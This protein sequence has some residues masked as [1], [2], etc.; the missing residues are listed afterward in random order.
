M[1]MTLKGLRL[2]LLS[3]ATVGA[4]A[5]VA[6]PAQAAD[7]NP[8]RARKVDE[9][10][11]LYGCDGGVRLDNFAIELQNVPGAKGYII[12]RDARERMRGAAHAW[13]EYF[14]KYFVEYR[15][16]E[17]SRLVLLDAADVP[18]E[19]LSM[20]LWLVPEGAE[21]PS[22]KPPGKREPRPFSGKFAELYVFDETA[23]YD[24]EGGSAGSFSTGIIYASFA[25]LLKKQPDSQGYLVV[26]SPPG[27][28]PGY[29]RRAGTRERQKVSRDEVTA[30]RMTV[31][32]G[33]AV[34][35]KKRKAPTAEGEVEEETYGRV[36][37]W[38]GPKEKPPVKH[39]EENSTLKEAL[40]VGGND[41]MDEE[42]EVADWMLDNLSEMMRG[43]K[44]SVGCIVV[45]PG[46]GT[47]LWNED[48]ETKRPAPDAFKIAERWK[49]ELIK[50]HGFDEQR[51]VVLSGPAE[52]SGSGKLE[53]WAVP[54]GAALPDPFKSTDETAGEAGEEEAEDGEAAETPPPTAR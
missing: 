11:R 48:G 4:L 14:V 12:A 18:G 10:G 50:K 40:F 32:N 37:L 5:A 19:D 35:A 51:V 7:D 31:I 34:P 52:D 25:G 41:F 26:Y 15:G 27:A 28:A 46:D 9:F 33:G 30:E 2:C 1:R 24:T 44:N 23:F 13:G 45:Y 54:Q 6:A 21:P 29:W 53:V 17:E 42:R 38:V 43:D 22:F 47:G 8:P 3:A 49:A 36:E 20:E 16:I 39:V